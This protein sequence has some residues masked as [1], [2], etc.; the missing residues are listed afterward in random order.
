MKNIMNVLRFE[1]KGFVSTK[2]YRAVTIIFVIGII[3]ATSIPQIVGSVQAKSGDE[4]GGFFQSTA[5]VVLSGEALSNDTYRNAFSPE[6]LKQVNGT[7]WVDLSRNDPP[8][9]DEAL[10]E[11]VSNGDYLFVLRYSGGTPCE[12]LAGNNMAAL[13]AFY[14][15]ENYITETVKRIETESLPAETQEAVNRISAIAAEPKIIEIGG[16]AENNFFIGYILILFLMYTILGYMTFVSNSIVTEKTSKAMELLITAV[17]PIHL[18]VGKVIGVGLAALTQVAALVAAGAVGIAI[19]L[20]Y[21]QETGGGLLGAVQGGNVGPA[22]AIII[23]VYFFLGFFL[24][25]FLTAAFS[26]TVS[27]PE[28][29]ATVNTLPI[30]LILVGFFLGIMTLSGVLGKSLIA[31]LSYVP[32]FTPITMVVRYTMGEVGIPQLVLGAV[33]L[34]AA[35]IVV[36]IL[37]AKIFRMGVM[38]YGVKATPKQLWR[39]LKSS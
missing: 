2:A 6:A 37:A 5:A 18:M 35:V 9:S 15:V 25:A 39:A 4:G 34:L 31:G 8:P 26:S 21:W 7:N 20:P 23:V 14:P 22:I 3:I 1:Y 24:Y 28:E 12:I 13:G 29:A 36:A 27:R 17:K 38:L 33:I 32:F 30:L 10:S 16:N 11:A 19:N